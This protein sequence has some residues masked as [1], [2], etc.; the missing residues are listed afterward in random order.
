MSL[1]PEKRDDNTAFLAYAAQGRREGYLRALSKPDGLH[2]IAASKLRSG[3]YFIETAFNLP[4]DPECPYTFP[5][6]VRGQLADLLSEVFLLYK[7]NQ[8]RMQRCTAALVEKD[9]SFQRFMARASV[10]RPP[11]RRPANGK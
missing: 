2:A 5:D 11:K 8:D 7:N 4:N 6:D 1:G 9:A 3:L 10:A